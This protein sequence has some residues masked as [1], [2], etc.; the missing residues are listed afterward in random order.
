MLPG[1]LESAGTRMRLLIALALLMSLT[2][3]VLAQNTRVLMDTDRGPLLIELDVA[4]APNTSANFLRYVDDGRYDRTLVQRIVP[5]FV[6]QGG[7][8]RENF[9]SITRY[10]NIGSE[11]G[12]GLRHLPGTIAMA[13]SNNANGTPNLSSASS[14]FFFNTVTNTSLDGIYTVF[15]KLVYGNRTLNEMATTP[16]FNN[17][18]EPIR[19]P[20]IRKAVRVPAGEFP[21]LPVHSGTWFDP[22]NPGKGFLI[23]V[24]G[25]AG[26]EAGPMMVVSWYDY[27]EGRQIWVSGIA[28]FTLG[29]TSVTVPLQITSGGQ[30]GAAFEPGQVVTNN[31]WGSITL[32][33]TGCDAGTFTYSSIYGNG[34][35]PVRSLTQPGNE[36]C[37]GQ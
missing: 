34:T 11:N 35:V 32:K 31:A 24:S 17:S 20:L 28:P 15:G 6:V 2:S 23:A 7:S 29:A 27:F 4:N 21:I 3:A 22:A 9:A 14:D 19:F 12:N 10:P 30:F 25:V 36:V 13:L 1:P 8:T 26:S 18:S 37:S 33:F 16:L 5:N